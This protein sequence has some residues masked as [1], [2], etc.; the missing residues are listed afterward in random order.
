MALKDRIAAAVA[1]V[2]QRKAVRV[3][4]HYGASRGPILAS[5]LA[6]QALF[7]VFAGIWVGFS[8]A[9]LVIRGDTGLMNSIIGVLDEAVPGLIA[10]DG[11]GS[12][13]IDPARLTQSGEPFTIAGVVA[14][15]GLLFASLGWLDSA[16]SSV[17]T[18]FDL[19]APATNPV[20]QKLVD[21]A[22]GLAFAALLLLAAGLTFAGSSATDLVL[23][24]LGV[25]RD[26][27]AG[28]VAGRIL[29]IVISVVVYAIALVGLY[30]FLSGVKVPW[31]QLRGG[32]IIGAIGIAVLTLLSGLL[33]G[34]ASNNPL[35][36]P[37]AVI[38]GLLI[39][40][41][42][43]CQIILIG[44]SW[45]AVD[46]ADDGIVLDEKVAAAR[47]EEARKLV[48]ANEPDPPAKRGFF[49]RL[50]RR[51]PPVTSDE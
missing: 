6:F 45:M 32:V 16:R 34:G 25:G 39:Y 33:L 46:V 1:W 26:S 42:F 8:I 27:V 40:Y 24:W 3:F 36:A 37:F 23:G 38:A 49:A 11:E 15:A 28:F 12:G 7:A 21:L 14:L 22:L 35:I 44:A 4:L 47:L 30:R 2:Q 5:G 43:V 10:A 20:L 13:A 19:P 41:N 50:F 31:R 9:A 48:A 18:L 29:S 17:R 51:T